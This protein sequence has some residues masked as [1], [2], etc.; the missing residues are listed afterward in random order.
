MN[1]VTIISAGALAISIA[2]LILT[3]LQR[4]NDTRRIVRQQLTD[5]LVRIA[6]MSLQWKKSPDEG[7]WLEP[8]ISAE[9]RLGSTLIGQLPRSLINDVDYISL[10]AALQ[11]DPLEAKRYYE[12]AIKAAGSDYYRNLTRSGYASLLFLRMG[13]YAAGREQYTEALDSLSDSTDECH[14]GRADLYW[15]WAFDEKEIGN[16]EK[17]VELQR[18]ATD[19]IAKIHNPAFRRY[20]RD[21]STKP[22]YGD[23]RPSEHP[24]LYLPHNS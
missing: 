3:Q 8:A 17:A 14:A 19:E 16:H 13:D 2:T 4:L 12:K 10:A 23:E 9:A 11:G 21:Q 5:C 20:K 7:E 18:Q 6:D 22:A 1:T 15:S 24:K